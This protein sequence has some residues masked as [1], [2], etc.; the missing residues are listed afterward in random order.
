MKQTERKLVSSEEQVVV[1]LRDL[2]PGQSGTVASLQMTAPD[3]FH[4]LMAMG[5]LPGVPVTL[6]RRFPSFVF[7]AG[8]SQFAV[9]ETIA[10]DILVQVVEG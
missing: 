1:P 5:V 8:Y 2:Q 4:K 3:R 6:L 10:T 9:D 7:A